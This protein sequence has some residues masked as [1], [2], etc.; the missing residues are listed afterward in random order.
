ML[1][2]PRQKSEAKNGFLSE[3]NHGRSTVRS[4][5]TICKELRLNKWNNQQIVRRHLYLEIAKDWKTYEI[6]RCQSK[7]NTQL[8]TYA[9]SQLVNVL[10]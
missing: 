1:P 9:A 2:H 6:Y 10:K 3:P 7:K 5:Q 8:I 4:I